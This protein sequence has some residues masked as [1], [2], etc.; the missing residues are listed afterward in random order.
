MGQGKPEMGQEPRQKAGV[1]LEALALQ[2]AASLAACL[3][4]IWP[5]QR[6][7]QLGLSLLQTCEVRSQ[8][9]RSEEKSLR[10]A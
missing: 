1:G 6:P 8:D 7:L 10:G 4:P 2:V 9:D 3:C 5:P